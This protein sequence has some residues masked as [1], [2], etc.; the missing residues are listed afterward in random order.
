MIVGKYKLIHPGQTSIHSGY[1]FVTGNLNVL[2]LCFPGKFWNIYNQKLLLKTTT[3]TGLLQSV[4]VF[5]T[6]IIKDWIA[7]QPFG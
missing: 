3:T 2:F 1:L 7:S 5:S 6:L 4:S